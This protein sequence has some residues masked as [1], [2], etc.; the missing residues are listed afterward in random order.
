MS[1]RTTLIIVMA[2]IICAINVSLTQLAWAVGRETNMP[3]MQFQP[4]FPPKSV[5][6]S[7]AVNIAVRNFPT[8]NNKFFKLRAAKANVTLAKTQYLPNLNLDVQESGVTANR[9]ASVVMNNVSGFD[10]VPVDSGPPATHTSFNP[11]VNS[12]QGANLNWLVVDFGLRHAND[13]FAYADAKVARADLNLTRLDVAFDAADAFL[14][15]VATKQVIRAAQAALE[16]MEAANLRAK[17]LVSKGLKAGVE[18]A[19][20]DFEVSRSKIVLIKAE[21]ERRLALIDLAEKMGTAKSDIDVVSEPLIRFPVEEQSQPFAQFDLNSH[22]YALLKTAEIHRWKAKIE[23]LNKAYRPHLWL[24]SSVYG[25]G[26]GENSVNPIRAVAGG[27]L[28]Q[29]FNYMI[30]ATFSF[31]VM[32][33][34]PLKAQKK[35]AYNNEMAAAADYDLAIQ[36]LE[37]KDARARVL[38]A[39]ARKVAKETPILVESAKVREIKVLK[40][41]STGLTNMATVAEAEKGLAQAEVEDALAQLE[42]WRSILALSYVQGDLKTFLNLVKIAEGNTGRSPNND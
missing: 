42:V 3:D 39:E 30:G 9:I 19:D 8:I 34:F 12:L 28:P 15:A 24:N 37:R 4:I 7:E 5:T 14:T 38:L 13:Q 17:V 10:T 26:S 35:I 21:R 25:R 27:G 33:Y 23:V 36:I 20:W 1:K 16:H 40:R 22:P 32:E 18:S 2:I 29:V 31:P 41:Y 6:I 11:I